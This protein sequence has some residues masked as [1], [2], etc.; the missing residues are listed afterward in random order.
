MYGLHEL[1]GMEFPIMETIQAQKGIA[2]WLRH[3]RWGKEIANDFLITLS[4]AQLLSGL[5]TPIL[6]DLALNIPHLKEEVMS[7]L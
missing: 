2:H 6:D 3:L 5:T 1:G 4:T 7:H